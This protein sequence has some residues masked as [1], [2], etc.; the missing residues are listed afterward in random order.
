MTGEQFF[1]LVRI[2]NIGDDQR[3]GLKSRAM[4]GNQVTGSKLKKMALI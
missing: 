2:A 1:K 4:M 3:F